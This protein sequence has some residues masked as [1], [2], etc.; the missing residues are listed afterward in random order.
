MLC[1]GNIDVQSR[2][3]T[4]ASRHLGYSKKSMTSQQ[5]KILFLKK[6]STNMFNAKI[7]LDLYVYTFYINCSVDENF[8]EILLIDSNISVYIQYIVI[9]QY[10]SH[11]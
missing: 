4:L 10:I 8:S 7:H 1:L 11:I 5:S 6:Q 9:Y 2:T 3:K